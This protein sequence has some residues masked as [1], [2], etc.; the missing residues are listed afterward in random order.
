MR[1]I[2]LVGMGRSGSTLLDLLLSS[3]SNVCSLGGVR[4]LADAHE[5]GCPCGVSNRT[6]CDF[7]RAVEGELERTIGRR[8]ESLDV[9]SRDEETFRRHNTALFEA[10]ART[11]GVEYIVDSSKS[12]SRLKRLLECTD[13]DIRPVHIVRDPR[14]YTL[15]QRKRKASRLAPAW[16]YVARSLRAY[17]LLNDQ[18]HTVVKYAELAQDPEGSLRKLMER[19]DLAFQPG[20]L[21]WA[22]WT[23]HNIGGGALLKKSNDSAIHFDDGWRELSAPT[24]ALIQ[25]IAWPGNVLNAAKARRWGLS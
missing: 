5:R 25:A 21:R 3:H 20:Q 16:S 23:H 2:Y 14:G 24:Q 7:W 9:D 4:R 19:L 6:Q 13:L 22:D 15:S 1:V 18:P 8:L 17:A 12:V 10:A 11:A